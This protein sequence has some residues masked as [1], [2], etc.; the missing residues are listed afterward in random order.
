M[1]ELITVSRVE[2]LEINSFFESELK[3]YFSEEN[4]ERYVLIPGS[5]KELC[6]IFDLPNDDADS[7]NFQNILGRQCKVNRKEDSFTF[8][9][10]FK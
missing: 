8:V 5:Q 7:C 10:Y 1:E 2:F 4:G 6:K 9:E 3:L